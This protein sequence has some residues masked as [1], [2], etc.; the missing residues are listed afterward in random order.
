[1]LSADTLVTS[2]IS[3]HDDLPEIVF[4]WYLRYS[5]STCIM[6]FYESYCPPIWSTVGAIMGMIVASPVHRIGSLLLREGLENK[7]PKT[8]RR[9]ALRNSNSPE[10]V[11]ACA[12]HPCR[13]DLDLPLTRSSDR[14]GRGSHRQLYPMLPSP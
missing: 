8:G 3:R 12:R 2:E 14:D 1:M 4:L 9:S 11:I 10:R 5:I 13:S 6:A 7:V